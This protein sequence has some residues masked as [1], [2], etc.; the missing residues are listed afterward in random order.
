LPVAIKEEHDMGSVLMRMFVRKKKRFER[1]T[2]KA[3]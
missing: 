2:E 1:R 3:A